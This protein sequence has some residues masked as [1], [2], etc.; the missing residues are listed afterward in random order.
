ME[1]LQAIKDLLSFIEV[2]WYVV[3]LYICAGFIVKVYM[4]D[5]I[6]VPFTKRNFTNAW[7][8][9][10]VGT[11]IVSLYVWIWYKYPEDLNRAGMKKLFISYIFTTSF[12]E[13]AIKDTIANA[14]VNALSKLKSKSKDEKTE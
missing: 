5:N 1:T 6:R 7:L 11:V 9:L 8:T 4:P 3:L 13:I 2:D 10:L 14:I 12:Y